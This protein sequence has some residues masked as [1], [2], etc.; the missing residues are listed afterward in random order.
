MT[1]RSPF[2]VWP[3]QAPPFFIPGSKI[4][5]PFRFLEVFETWGPYIDGELLKEQAVTAFQKG[6]W[7]KEKAVLL[8]EK[9]TNTETYSVKSVLLLLLWIYIFII[10]TVWCGTPAGSCYKTWC[11]SSSDRKRAEGNVLCGRR[12]SGSRKIAQMNHSEPAG[13]IQLVWTL[14]F[15]VV[16]VQLQKKGCCLYTGSS[17]SPSL[18]WSALCT[19]QPSLNSTLCAS[20]TSTCLCTETPTAGTC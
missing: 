9:H 20:Y 5:N 7:Q 16:Q 19:S 18:Q 10:C 6:H 3:Y 13:N 8:G 1:V 2:T 12:Q 17:T 14:L 15:F 4:V 11:G